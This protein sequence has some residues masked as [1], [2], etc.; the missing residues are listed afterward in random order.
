MYDLA[1]G[2]LDEQ[3]AIML[4]KA[5]GENTG[6]EAEDEEADLFPAGFALSADGATLYAALNLDN[7]VAFIDTAAGEV[8]ERVALDASAVP[9]DIG[10]LPYAL[11]LLPEDNKLYLSEWN[12]GGVS[13]IDRHRAG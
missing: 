6:G 7:S 10:P 4:G 2:R 1:D 5:E 12:G 11:A 13:V 3:D 8:R 9:E